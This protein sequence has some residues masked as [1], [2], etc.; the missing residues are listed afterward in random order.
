MKKVKKAKKVKLGKA[1]AVNLVKLTFRINNQDYVFEAETLK[2]AVEKFYQE[3]KVVRLP[4]APASFKAEKNGKETILAYPYR[5]L[6][7]LLLSDILGQAA[8]DIL[9]RRLKMFLGEEPVS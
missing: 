6:T 9:T 2:E 7:R 8:R 1:K 3:L 4:A 5:Q